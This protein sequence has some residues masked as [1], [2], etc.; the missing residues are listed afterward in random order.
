MA[1]QLEVDG[2][3]GGE[4]GQVWQIFSIENLIFA[5]GTVDQVHT[6]AILH[7]EADEVKEVL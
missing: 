5:Q 3:K 4:E 1:V 6:F 2:L 7:S